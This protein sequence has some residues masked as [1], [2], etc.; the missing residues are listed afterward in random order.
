MENYN[1][2]DIVRKFIINYGIAAVVDSQIYNENKCHIL[3]RGGFSYNLEVVNNT[4]YKDGAAYCK[5][6]DL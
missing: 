4:L 1:L 2:K 6:E 3:L 5:I